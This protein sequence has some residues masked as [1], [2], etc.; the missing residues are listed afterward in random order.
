MPLDGSVRPRVAKAIQ[1]L[2]QNPLPDFEGGYGNPLGS[3]HSFKLTNLLKCKL[4]KDGIH[5]VCQIMHEGETMR[6]V[7]I[8]ARAD[9]DVYRV[10]ARRREKYGL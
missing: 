5:I 7:V 6:I 10:A 8:G 2:A 3:K 4:R 1:K 9:E